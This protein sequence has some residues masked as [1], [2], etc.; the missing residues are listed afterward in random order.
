MFLGELGANAIIPRKNAA[1]P[2]RTSA[3]GALS[4]GGVFT[5]E[6]PPLLTQEADL[7][8]ADTCMK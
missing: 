5:S 1:A 2:E 7:I 3:E 6:D 8:Q 4:A